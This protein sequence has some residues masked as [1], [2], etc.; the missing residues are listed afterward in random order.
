MEIYGLEAF[1]YRHE[2]SEYNGESFLDTIRI[3]KKG[4]LRISVDLR[5]GESQESLLRRFRKSVSEARVLPLVRQKRWFTS[6]SEVN[7]IKK[8]KAIRK[9]HR[10]KWRGPE[11][12]SRG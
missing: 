2:D 8:Q 10:F 5:P 12:R 6:K 7:R 1:C 9:A 3:W 11:L 4:A